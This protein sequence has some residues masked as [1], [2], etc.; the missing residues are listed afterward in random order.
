MDASKAKNRLNAGT[1][2]T[3]WN[4]LNIKRLR[5]VLVR[6]QRAT[7]FLDSFP[8]ANTSQ[9]S[10]RRGHAKVKPTGQVLT[11]TY[12]QSEQAALHAH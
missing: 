2:G 9:P 7:R 12:G 1:W 8:V 3:I 5:L 10:A 6:R 11:T 4:K